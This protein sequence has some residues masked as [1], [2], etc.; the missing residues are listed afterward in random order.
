MTE[1]AAWDDTPAFL[2]RDRD[3]EVDDYADPDVDASI[4]RELFDGD[5]SSLDYETRRALIFVLRDRFV[6]GRANPREYKA[7]VA[8]AHLIRKRLN[9]LL[10]VLEIDTQREVAY[11]RQAMAPQSVPH[12]P[13]LLRRTAWNKEET[14]LL[15]HLRAAAR[16]AAGAGRDVEHVDRQSMLGHV[17][18]MR[19]SAATNLA[20]DNGK[21]DAAIERLRRAGIL[22]GAE[23]ASEYDFDVRLLEA[24]IDLPT[25]NRLLDQLGTPGTQQIGGQ[26]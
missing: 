1:T 4:S 18:A 24:L 20:R 9:D 15:T 7:L 26:P 6:S 3:D 10:L 11:K 23:R 2:S 21:A 17:A 14:I 22:I 19:P 5:E 12:S 13:S 8:G 25:L 16:V